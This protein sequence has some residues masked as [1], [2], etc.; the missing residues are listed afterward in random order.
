M[1]GDAQCRWDIMLADDPELKILCGLDFRLTNTELDMS[2]D[3]ILERVFRPGV[4]AMLPVAKK[5]LGARAEEIA[6]T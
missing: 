6:A 2:V 4:K 3:D 5:H 1:T